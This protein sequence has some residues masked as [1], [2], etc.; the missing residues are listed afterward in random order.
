MKWGQSYRYDNWPLLFTP[1]ETS[2][3]LKKIGRKPFRDG[4]AKWVKFW[5]TEIMWRVL[6]LAL[7][8]FYCTKASCGTVL[9]PRQSRLSSRAGQ[10]EQFSEADWKSSQD[11]GLHAVR[12]LQRVAIFLSHCQFRIFACMCLNFRYLNLHKCMSLLIT[13]MIEC[14]FNRTRN[15]N[16]IHSPTGILLLNIHWI[17]CKLETIHH[18]SIAGVLPYFQFSSV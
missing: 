1:T 16:P 4:L 18:A 6:K 7:W 17:P 3:K 11:Q 8:I 14:V 10:P 9:M 13:Y 12:G 2:I 5:R 15:A